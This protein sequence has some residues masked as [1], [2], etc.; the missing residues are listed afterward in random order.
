MVAVPG[1]AGNSTEGCSRTTWLVPPTN[2]FSMTPR[3]ASPPDCQAT[4]G[5][6]HV[7][8]ISADSASTPATVPARP[9][10]WSN[11]RRTDHHP[12]RRSTAWEGESVEP[13][14]AA[15]DG[16][17]RAFATCRRPEVRSPNGT[18]L[19]VRIRDRSVSGSS[20]RH[21]TPRC[22]LYCAIVRGKA[23]SR[24]GADPDRYSFTM[25]DLHCWPVDWLTAFLD[26]RRED[27]LAFA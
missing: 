27:E 9:M 6:A 4:A 20:S 13:Q 8:E 7:P 22:R 1:T 3:P 25:V 24:L 10:G 16:E 15:D 19:P 23:T 26:F 11:P 5:C 18:G 21:G 14:A 2:R 17:A 12:E